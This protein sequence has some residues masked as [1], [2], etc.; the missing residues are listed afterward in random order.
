ME[1]S[2]HEQATKFADEAAETIRRR[3]PDSGAAD[4]QNSERRGGQIDRRRS[5]NVGRGFNRRRLARLRFLGARAARLGFKLVVH[6]ASCS[7]L[8]VRPAK[9][10][11]KLK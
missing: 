9:T 6:H 3:I 5:G 10:A 7:V 11:D 4:D 2:G 1:K 8:V